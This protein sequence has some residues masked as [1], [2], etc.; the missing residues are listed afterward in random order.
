MSQIKT[1]T[2][3]IG[4][5]FNKGVLLAGDTQATAYPS[6]PIELK[7]KIDQLSSNIAICYAGTAASG[8]VLTKYMKYYMII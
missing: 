4:L 6:L 5:K 3:I 7:S 2:T 1:G 8:Q